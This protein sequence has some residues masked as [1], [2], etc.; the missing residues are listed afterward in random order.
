MTAKV[1]DYMKQIDTCLRADQVL[2]EAYRLLLNSQLA[3]LPLLDAKGEVLGMVTRESIFKEGLD[4][5][6][7]S[8][9]IT[10]FLMR[11]FTVLDENAKIEEVWPLNHL[12]CPIINSDKKVLGIITKQQ[13]DQAYLDGLRY[14]VNLLEATFNSAH[15]G[16]FAIDAQGYLTSMNPAAE[17]FAKCA[18]EEAIGKF[19]TDVVAPAGLLDI[20]KTGKPQYGKKFQVGRRKFIT[21]RTPIVQDG[22]VI[23]AV[24]IIQDISEIEDVCQEL[25]TVKNLN[26]ELETIINLSKDAILVIND[27]GLVEKANKST[28]NVLGLAAEKLLETDIRELIEL[29][30]FNSNLYTMMCEKQNTISLT[31]F[32]FNG[33]KLHILLTPVLD[34]R[35]EV[36]KWVINVRDVSKVLYL[37]ERLEKVE[38][39]STSYAK[40]LSFLRTKVNAKFF[41]SQDTNMKQILE[42]AL[43]VAQVDSTVLIHSQLGVDKELIARAIHDNSGYSKGA[44]I[45]I[46]CSEIPQDLLEVELFGL[47]GSDDLDTDLYKKSGLLELAHNGTIF[48]DDI[49]W[50]PLELQVKLLKVIQDGEVSRVGG[51]RR[52]RVNARVIAATNT[53]L[54]DRIRTGKFRHDLYYRLNVIPIFIPTFEEKK[55]DI[56][57]MV[58]AFQKKLNNKMGVTKKFSATAVESLI[59]RTWHGE[60]LQLERIIE[61]IYQHCTSEIIGEDDVEKFL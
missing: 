32:N 48:I 39:L 38:Q 59:E 51:A 14:R 54:Q 9:P 33:N 31:Y 24:G 55:E 45:F 26:N 25:T 20:V 37:Q 52:Q 6:H 53:D 42:L 18:K 16:I 58:Q 15:N 3:G 35:Q 34:S 30:V 23:G 49:E 17:G 10:K 46:K 28:L 44:F 1:R 5:M 8:T 19:L 41:Q 13:L 27:K 43:R 60:A 4:N 56:L 29:G 36:S 57:K 11:E 40:E 47:E 7:P 2:E 21:N 61:D 22:G 12:V 50:L